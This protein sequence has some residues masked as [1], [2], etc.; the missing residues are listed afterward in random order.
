MLS[1]IQRLVNWAV[2]GSAG[3]SEPP[4]QPPAPDPNKEELLNLINKLST[5][6]L[7]THSAIF[8]GSFRIQ[9]HG[10]TVNAAE[11]SLY[12]VSPSEYDGAITNLHLSNEDST[13]LLK[14]VVNKFYNEKGGTDAEIQ[15]TALPL[16]LGQIINDENKETTKLDKN[17][18]KL[19]MPAIENVN[20]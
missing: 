8:E 2:G 7:S 14:R 16:L 9:G 6:A 20:F 17:T 3:G 1:G 5:K 19:S 4:V 11:K 12:S 10:A 15:N 13:N 18:I